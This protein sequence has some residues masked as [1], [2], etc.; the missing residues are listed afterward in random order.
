MTATAIAARR[1]GAGI[2]A[3]LLHPAGF[4]ATILEPVIEALADHVEVIVPER[5]GYGASTDRPAPT[6]IEDASDDLALLLDDLE[7]EQ[8]LIAGVSAGAT[9][10]LAFALRHPDRTAAVVSHEPL[11]GPIAPGLHEIVTG[12]VEALLDEPSEHEATAVSVFMSELV[13]TPTW[14]QLPPRWRDEV[15]TNAATTR[16]EVALFASFAI[17]AADLRRLASCGTVSSIGARSGP[18]RREVA[19]V[20]VAHG[21]PVRTLE[22]CGHLPPV[23]SPASFA[24]L[25]LEIAERSAVS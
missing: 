20:L 17:D 19:Q 10:S 11:L 6:S 21:V 16:R 1:F 25:V 23:D 12:R 24:D 22:E 8:V 7:L 2:P 15:R 5:R 3:V 13:G 9:L 14:N 18:A 4:G